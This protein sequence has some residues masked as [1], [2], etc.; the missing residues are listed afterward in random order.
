MR[1][2]AAALATALL[3]A[4]PGRSFAQAPQSDDEKAIYA[5][6]VLMGR[7]VGQFNL[8]KHEQ[9]LLKKGL[10]DQLN[11][12][13]P[14]VDVDA[15]Q[16]HIRDLERA[17]VGQAASAY[18]EKAAKEKGVEKTSSGLVYKSLK[19]GSGESPRE[20]DTVKVHYRGTLTSGVEFDSSY[21][22]NEPAE[23]PLNRV[24]PCWTEGVQK[25]KVGGKARLV[26]P[27]SIGYGD[28]GSPPKIPGGATLVFEVEL[29]DIKK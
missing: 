24:I 18:L 22:R 19:E 3:L 6:G 28:R 10:T 29:L 12:Q 14:A 23:F 17:R 25:M 13:K 26:C 11:G 16:P 21:A 5:L 1:T 2:A 8:S 4:V 15:A 27:S 9:D 7:S 20:T